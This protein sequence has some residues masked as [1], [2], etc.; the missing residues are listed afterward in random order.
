MAT[1][2]HRLEQPIAGLRGLGEADTRADVDLVLTAH[3]DVVGTVSAAADDIAAA[4]D[5]VVDS[6][7]RGGRLVHLGA[8]TSGWLAALDATETVVTFGVRGRVESVVAGGHGL[9][10][11]AMSVGDDDV[12]GA[13]RDPVLGTLGPQDV[14]LAV[15]ASGR[16]PFTVAGAEVARDR[17][18]GTIALVSAD[19]SPL[20]QTSSVVVCVPVAGEVIGGSTRLTAGLA[21]KLVLN[22][23]S[24]VAMVRLGRAVRGHMVCVEPLNDKLRARAVAAI[25]A[26]TGASEADAA[27]TLSAAGGAGDVATVALIA[28]VDVSTAAQR[29]AVARGSI[30]AAIG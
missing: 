19:G 11:T 26:A 23:I 5:L 17:G 28:G 10:P 25:A 6:L 29:L 22:T 20:A 14:V 4:I 16:T 8:G 30:T 2:D 15:S 12:E 7:S 27:V 24:T 21:Q 13:R 3:G 9:D 18:A 1:S